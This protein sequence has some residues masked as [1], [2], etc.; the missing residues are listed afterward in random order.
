MFILF[1]DL[2]SASSIFVEILA[3]SEAR[4]FSAAS[5][6]GVSAFARTVNVYLL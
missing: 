4:V 1:L 2:L 6:A 3:P 5:I